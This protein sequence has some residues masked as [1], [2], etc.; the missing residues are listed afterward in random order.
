MVGTARVKIILVADDSAISRELI[1][2][3]LETEHR[4]VLEACDGR[5]ALEM[6][7]KSLP[8]LVLMDIQMPYF[9]GY[10]VLE[11]LRGDA[12]FQDVPVIAVT[13]YAMQGDRERVLSAGFDGYITKPIEIA[14]LR[15]QVELFLSSY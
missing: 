5:N 15:E 9:D 6:I 2:E 13:A 10:A 11:Q 1:R 12:R 4:R 3:A 8:D 14:R 7:R